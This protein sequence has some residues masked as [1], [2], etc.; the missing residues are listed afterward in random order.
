MRVSFF[1]HKMHKERQDAHCARKEN[2]AGATALGARVLQAK[3]YFNSLCNMQIAFCI[4]YYMEIRLVI[5][6]TC[7]LLAVSIMLMVLF[8]TQPGEP[9]AIKTYTI[10]EKEVFGNGLEWEVVQTFLPVF[11]YMFHKENNNNGYEA[12]I[13]T[14][15]P[16]YR[17]LIVQEAV[18]KTDEN[19]TSLAL[20]EDIRKQLLE[21]NVRSNLQAEQTENSIVVEEN[22][23]ETDTDEKQ[24]EV[25][26]EEIDVAS[27]F[28]SESGFEPVTEKQKE[29]IWEDY[30]DPEKIRQEFYAI[31]ATTEIEDERI[32]PVAL[33]E[34]DLTIEKGNGGPQILIYHTHS[35]ETFADSVPGDENSSIV[36][37]GEYLAN[38]LKEEYGFEVLHHTGEYDVETR[39]Y[40]YSYSL[41]NIEAL[42]KEYPSIE[43]V[44]DLHRDAVAEETKLVSEQNGKQ[45]A[46]VMFFNGLSHTIKQGDIGYLENP[47]IDDNLAFSFQMQ[48]LCNEY[49]PGLTRRIYLKGYRYNMHLKPKTLL[50]E[51]GAQTNTCEEA[52]NTLDIVAHAL[53]MC[54][55]G[56]KT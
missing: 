32:N 43:V 21:E 24:T 52:R 29:Y 11:G 37:A 27:V 36:G 28:L 1:M 4:S 45:A 6:R 14:L 40:A 48:V 22:K 10:S 16:L 19:K 5:R 44:I 42:L 17:Y 53:S 54:L 47:Y 56:E 55:G 30:T 15:S 33:L 49:Y 46:Q 2:V 9:K 35:Q 26:Q 20:G 31:D 41:P 39:D 23:E 50:I 8:R 7:A 3:L 12:V 51:L 34:K 38:I 25:P 18:V 13:G